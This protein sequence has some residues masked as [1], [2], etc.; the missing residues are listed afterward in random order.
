MHHLTS[1]IDNARRE[2]LVYRDEIIPRSE[3]ALSS[4]QIAWQSSKD[5]FRDVLDSRRMLLEARTMYFKAVADQYKAI[6]ELVLCC[7]VGDLEALE[8]IDTETNADWKKP[9][10]RKE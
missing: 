1:M 7:G 2:A 3:R 5:A 10:E 4:A 9:R 6:S 8:M